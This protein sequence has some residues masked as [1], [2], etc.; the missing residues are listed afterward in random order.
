MKTFFVLSAA[1]LFLIGSLGFSHFGMEMGEQMTNCPF[2]PGQAAICTMDPL[3]HIAAWQNVFTAL[4]PE[5]ILIFLIFA[6]LI[7]FFVGHRRG[8]NHI[9]STPALCLSRRKVE[10]PFVLSPLEKAFWRGT[11]H[12][13]IF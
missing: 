7:F 2:M 5:N 1:A 3:E 9:L 6:S 12:P 13:K 8:T 4:A 11:L 10:T